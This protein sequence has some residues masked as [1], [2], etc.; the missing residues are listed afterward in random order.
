[1]IEKIN[2]IH[3][4]Q[5]A[6]VGAGPGGIEYLTLKALK[7][8][9]LAD[10]ILYDDLIKD[11]LDDL[12]ATKAEIINV[13]K[14]LMDGIDQNERQEYINTLIFNY[15][16]EGKRVVRLKGG[17]PMLFGKIHEEI[18]FLKSKN[19]DFEI[20]PGISAGQAGAAL[21]KIPLTIR[22]KATEVL[23]STAHKINN[24]L[25]AYS[26]MVATVNEGT[27]I[28]IYMG[29]THIQTIAQAFIDKGVDNPV[30]INVLSQV[31]TKDESIFSSTLTE[32]LE[33][34]P[35]EIK[36]PALLIIGKHAIS[37]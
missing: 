17:D 25:T 14:R 5:V 30:H 10:V 22:G 2:H 20:I 4:K 12:I 8:L 31:G 36:L 21:F 3:I 29:G 26:K 28:I 15:H 18:I 35:A 6:L 11:I 16:R 13:G 9:G 23:L 33:N 24:E 1:M 19:I 7:A 37:Y 27:P 32:I 34:P